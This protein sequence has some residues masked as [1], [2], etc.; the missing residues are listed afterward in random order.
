[1][2]RFENAHRVEAY[3]GLVP[4][5]HSSSTREHKLGITKAGPSALRRTL[6]QAAWSARR[7]RGNHP[8]QE[9]ANEIEKRRGKRI[10]TT[11]LARKLAGILYALWRDGT[12]Y[13][14]QLTSRPLQSD[15]QGDQRHR[16]VPEDYLVGPTPRAR[17]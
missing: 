16:I 10:A 3:L 9:W 12:T 13:K 5:E 8:M 15:A 1:V 17:K 14:P 2:E 11:A 6:V 4:G 7:A